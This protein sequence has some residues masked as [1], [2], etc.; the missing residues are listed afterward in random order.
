MDHLPDRIGH[1]RGGRRPA[2]ALLLALLFFWTTALPALALQGQLNV[3]TA[4]TSELEQL[5][6]IGAAK[7]RAIIE[8]RRHGQF[9]DLT[10]LKKSPAIGPST[11]QAIQPYLK[12]SGPHTLTGDTAAQSNATP[13]RQ[14]TRTRVSP[15]ILT[16][17]GEIQLL[18]DGLYYDTLGQLIDSAKNRIDIAM[19]LFKTS[20]AQT[21]RA[22]RIMQRLIAARKRGVRIQVVLEQSGYDEELNKEN[23]RTAAILRRNSIPVAFDGRE[24]TT[25][26]KLVVLD[27]RLCLVGSHNFTHSALGSNHEMTLL[28]DNQ[29]LAKE[30]LAYMETLP[31]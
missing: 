11:F 8:L 5:P 25:H 23:Q 18:P 19:F 26:A 3:N 31:Q 16:R 30:L 29:D 9:H 10:E 12:L 2:T 17:P 4:T 20:T 27:Q 14:Q 13:S 21:N 24:V 6:F 1:G 15:L 22:R 28:V 7:A